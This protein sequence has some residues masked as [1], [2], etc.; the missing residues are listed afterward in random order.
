MML[1]GWL[2]FAVAMISLYVIVRCYV[3]YSAHEVKCHRCGSDDV[4]WAKRYC[5]NCCT[6]L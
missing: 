5:N 1:S 6:V 3:T 4:C 2:F